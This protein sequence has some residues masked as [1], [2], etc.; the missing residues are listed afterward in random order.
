MCVCRGCGASSVLQINDT[1][2]HQFVRKRSIELQIDLMIRKARK[3]GGGIVDITKEENL[4]TMI[5][6]MGSRPFR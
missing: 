2:L 6:V 5:E 1:D 4:E 3:T